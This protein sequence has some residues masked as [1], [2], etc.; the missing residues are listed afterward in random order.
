MA[1]RIL[2]ICSGIGGAM[3]RTSSRPFLVAAVVTTG[4]LALTACGTPPW[5]SAATD[6]AT[7]DPGRASASASASGSPSTAA[8]T[9]SA[10]P[11]GDLVDGALSRTVRAGDLVV[12]V[13]YW[14]TLPLQDWTAGSA[15]PLSMSVSSRGGSDV[16]LVRAAVETSALA[17]DGSDL[18]PGGQP[19]AQTDPSGFAVS[20]PQSWSGTFVLGPTDDRTATMRVVV[21][22]VFAEGSGG[23]RTQQTATDVLSIDLPTEG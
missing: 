11:G 16:R 12:G 7:R 15:K 5:E 3:R 4:A 13:R 19:G 9:P 22:L 21:T 23:S 6:R 18:P 8:S 1:L 20:R 10:R 2:K 17:R 14:S